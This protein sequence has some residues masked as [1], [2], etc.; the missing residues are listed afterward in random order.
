MNIKKEYAA[1]D[2]VW[3]HGVD[4]KHNKLT[5]GTVIKVLDLSD[6]GH[7]G[8]H[9]IVEIPTHIEPLLEIRT[10]ENIS[11]DEIGPI[12]GFREFKELIPTLKK[13]KTVG[14]EY[15]LDKSID[16]DYEPS[17]EEIHAALEK[18]KLSVIHQPLNM[19][20]AKPKRRYYRGKKKS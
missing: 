1:G 20:D 17:S 9:Y 5:Q 12:G 10:W 16:L 3:I 8:I 6:I 4:H 13:I 14:F 15:S 18:S 19:K 11:Q 7:H 2:V